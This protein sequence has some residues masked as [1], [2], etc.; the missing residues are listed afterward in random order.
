MKKGLSIILALIMVVSTMACLT[1]FA[2]ASYDSMA[3]ARNVSFGTNYSGNISSSDKADFY[4][5]TLNKSSKINVTFSGEAQYVYV[6]LFDANG[7]QLE[8]NNPSKSSSGIIYFSKDYDLVS[9]V[10][11]VKFERDGYDCSYTCSF[12][13]T[14]ANETFPESL[15][16]KDDTMQTANVISPNVS[17]VGQLAVNDSADFYKINLN[18][19]S[20][21][22]LQFNGPQS[23]V[24]IYLFDVNG[25]QVYRNNPSRGNSGEISYSQ[26]YHLIQGVYYLKIQRDSGNG[27]YRFKYNVVNSAESFPET[28]SDQNNTMTTADE[29]SF[30]KSYIGQ[31]AYN[32]N[33]DFYKFTL[34]TSG[35]IKLNFTG[36]LL[37]WIYIYLF[38]ANGN[39]LDKN[40]VSKG[41]NND[42]VFNEVYDLDPG[43]Y[44]IKVAE[45]SG[46]GNYSFNLSKYVET[47]K[48]AAANQ[49]NGIKVSWNAVSGAT[50]Y[51]VF[52][53]QAGSNTWVNIGTTTNAYLLDK[54]VANGKYYAYSIRAYDANGSYS[55]YESAKNYT[56]KFVATP[57]LTGI[58]NATDGVYVKWNAVPGAVEYRVYRRG[59]G[60]YSWTYLGSTKSLYYTDK[61]VKYDSG[62]Y[63]RYTVRAVSSYFSGFDSNGLVIK[64]LENPSLRNATS[65]SSGITVKW[66]AVSGTTGYYVYRRTA[67]SNWTRIAAVG[68]TNNTTYLDRGARKGVTY[69]YTVRAVYG[70]TTS[71]YNSGISCYDK[72]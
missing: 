29:I 22:T 23:Y 42:I 25:N 67:G 56:A 39:Q 41:N 48:A 38:D 65:S 66:S 9:G 68:G 50:K 34:N 36:Y 11:Y 27:A 44:Y 10:Y 40:N 35:Q 64:R 46:H 26:S 33:C 60:S 31:I 24:Y 53:R 70:S 72:Y 59:A 14:S 54:N 28:I 4:K 32:D 2:S 12:G 57:K 45:D 51:V 3:T 16:K 58:S 21:F 7:V 62:D 17:Y 37:S 43:T 8:R 71:A 20:K 15:S 18:T 30:G 69:T 52:R 13:A 1:T 47:P 5:I 61:G 19:S 63:Y 55:A 6:Y 49:T